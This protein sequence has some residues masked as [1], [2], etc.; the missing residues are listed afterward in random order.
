MNASIQSECIQADLSSLSILGI[1]RM[2]ASASRIHVF[3]IIILNPIKQT[4]RNQIPKCMT[5]LSD[6]IFVE[7]CKSH[8]Q[9]GLLCLPSLLTTTHSVQ[10]LVHKKFDLFY[11]ALNWKTKI[12]KGEKL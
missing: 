9:I 10:K 1:L 5:K 4:C 12:L 11:Y 3:D 7:Y 8:T 6:T 2:A